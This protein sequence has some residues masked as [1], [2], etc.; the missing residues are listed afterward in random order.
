[1]TGRWSLGKRHARIEEHARG[2]EDAQTDESL[3]G[4]IREGSSDFPSGDLLHELVSVTAAMLVRSFDAGHRLGVD[5]VLNPGDDRRPGFRQVLATRC[6]VRLIVDD[7]SDG[8]LHCLRLSLTLIPPRQRLGEN[9]AIV[10]RL[11]SVLPADE[12]VPG[13]DLNLNGRL[14]R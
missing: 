8:W 14:W 7:P 12:S 10:S 6:S 13:G 1:M 9:S 3:L 11:D 4:E 5:E 2:V